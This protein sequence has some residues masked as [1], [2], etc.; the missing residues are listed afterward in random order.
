MLKLIL[1]AL[2]NYQKR[3]A[4]QVTRETL[5]RL[6]DAALRDLGLYRAEIES[7]AAER[8]HLAPRTRVRAG[9]PRIPAGA[10]L[11]MK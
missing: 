11:S 6:D 8:A 4:A 5:E 3:R 10:T 7:I 2:V 9:A 1:K